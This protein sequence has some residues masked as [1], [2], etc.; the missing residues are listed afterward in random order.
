[1]QAGDGRGAATYFDSQARSAEQRDPGDARGQ[2][3]GTGM[4]GGIGGGAGEWRNWM[5]AA[6]VAEGLRAYVIDYVPIYAS[7]VGASFAYWE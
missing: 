6:G 5:A 4:R 3:G 2:H 1:M 7:P